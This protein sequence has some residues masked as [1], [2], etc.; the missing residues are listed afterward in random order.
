DGLGVIDW[1]N[2]RHPDHRIKYLI[3]PRD[4]VTTA[5][6]L[7]LDANPLKTK[8]RRSV[9]RRCCL[10]DA[11]L[12]SSRPHSTT[13]R[14]NRGTGRFWRGLRRNGSDSGRSSLPRLGYWSR[15]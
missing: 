6:I 5:L 4:L 14:R 11:V 3:V 13:R 8:Q 10:E 9:D 2:Y 1:L 7:C 12:S 15:R